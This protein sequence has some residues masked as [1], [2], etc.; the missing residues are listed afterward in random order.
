MAFLLC[1][2]VYDVTPQRFAGPGVYGRRESVPC[3]RGIHESSAR[4]CGLGLNGQ[5]CV[6]TGHAHKR[7]C[8]GPQIG[9]VFGSQVVFLECDVGCSIP[10]CGVGLQRPGGGRSRIRHHLQPANGV[11][12]ARKLKAMDGIR[13]CTIFNQTQSGGL[14]LGGGCELGWLHVACACCHTCGNECDARFQR[15]TPRFTQCGGCHCAQARRS[16]VWVRVRRH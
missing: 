12:G 6:G 1:A 13:H 10:V 15:A 14:G 16:T 4:H 5:H 7:V 9:N 2:V 11:C 8:F 3:D